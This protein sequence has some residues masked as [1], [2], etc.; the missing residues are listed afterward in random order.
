MTE[1]PSTRRRTE[2]GAAMVLGAIFFAFLALPLCAVGVDTAR[3]WVEAQRL[4]AA[5]DAASTAGVTYMPDDF[6]A[7]KA[8]ALQIATINGYTAGGGT[9]VTIAPG[10][11]PTQLKVTITQT[12]DNFFAK[13]FGVDTST[14]SR[15]AMADY[16]GPAPMGSPCNTFG[17]EPAGG[18][19]TSGPV[20]SQLTGMVPTLANCSTNP[21]YWANIGGPDWPKNNGDQFMTRSCAGGTAG[22]TGTKNDEFDPLGYFYVVRV[23]PSAVNKSVRIQ[24]YDPAFVAQGD[25]CERGPLGIEVTANAWNPYTSTDAIDRY[26]KQASGATNSF[27]TGDVAS[28]PVPTITSFGLRGVVASKDPRQ[29]P[30]LS[31]CVRQYPGYATASLRGDT[32]LGSP[33]AATYDDDLAKVFHQWVTMCDFTPTE[34]GDYYIQ[35]RTNVALNTSS[36]DGNGGY[37]GN[38]AVYNQ[39]TDNPAVGG[40]GGNRFAI[41]AF[42]SGISAGDLSVSAH[43]RMAIYANATGAN[44]EFNLVRVIPSAAGK[45]L[46]FGFFDVGEAASGGTMQVMPPADSNMSSNIAGCKGSGVVNGTLTD[47]KITGIQSSGWNGKQQFIRVPIPTNYSCTTS[48]QG[49]C[50]FRVGV[51]FGGGNVVNDSTTWTAKIEGEPVRLVE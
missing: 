7:A 51:N 31:T 28:T 26:K 14:I 40:G 22:C 8:R 16:N 25:F 48:S 6:A 11:R 46:V 21:Q 34:A 33:P 29:A 12:V 50:W 15:G 9:T 49:G 37:Q 24:L 36:P 32:L 2:R 23:G 20:A 10:D 35:V 39:T 30:P 41:R 43:E 5:A 47:C 44:S 27:C 17:N 18:S 13:S 42:G 38:M 1:Q 45:T 3:W 4:Q 19:T